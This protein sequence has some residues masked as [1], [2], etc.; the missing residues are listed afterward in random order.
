MSEKRRQDL[1]Y[2]PGPEAQH[3]QGRT[4][5][6]AEAEYLPITG[7][8]FSRLCLVRHDEEAILRVLRTV[9]YVDRLHARMALFQA[10]GGSYTNASPRA[11]ALCERVFGPGTMHFPIELSAADAPLQPTG[12]DPRAARPPAPRPGPG[13]APALDPEA[14]FDQGRIQIV[15]QILQR[16]VSQPP[17]PPAS[18][19]LTL[20]D[21]AEL[22]VVTAALRRLRSTP[23]PGERELGRT[24][25]QALQQ[26]A[27]ESAVAGHD[28]GRRETIERMIPVWPKAGRS[29]TPPP[30]PVETRRLHHGGRLGA[31]Q[32]LGSWDKSPT[33]A[34][35]AR[36]QTEAEERLA[37]DHPALAVLGQ[38]GGEPLPEA[39]LGRM[40]RIL[41][42]DFSHVRIHTDAAA[43]EAT[44]LLG[45]R[46]LA[47][48]AHVYFGAGQFAP[49]T[50]AGDRLL[51]HELVHVVQFDEGRLPPA[52]RAG[53][54]VSRPEDRAEQEAEARTQGLDPLDGA[55]PPRTATAAQ[56]IIPPR[57]AAPSSIPE[58]AAAVVHLQRDPGRTP[59]PT[60]GSTPGSTPAPAPTPTSAPASTTSPTPAPTPAGTTPAPQ[61]PSPS[62]APLRA[63]TPAAP[64]TP[65]RGPAATPGGPTPALSAPAPAPGPVGARGAG[66]PEPGGSGAAFADRLRAAADAQRQALTTKAN[67]VKASLGT[68]FDTE[69]QR[70]VTGFDQLL[71]R[72]ES[73]RDQALTALATRSE[74][75]KARVRQA[76][77]T[78]HTKLDA[79]LARQQSAARQSGETVAQDAITQAAAQ[80]DHATQGSATRAQRARDL[81]A[82][83]A[84]KFAGLDGGDSV[85]SD[86]RSKAGELA[87]TIESRASEARRMCADHGAK[88]AQDL[89][90]D[91]DDVARG[92][93]DKIKES[94]ERIDQ[95]RDDA[96]QAIDDGVQGAR[97]G[98]RQS[99]EQ[100]RQEIEQKKT[101]A[102]QGYDQLRDG[103]RAQVDAALA[104][105]T[106]KLEQLVQQMQRDVDDLVQAAAEIAIAPEVTAEAHAGIERTLAQHQAKLAEFGARGTASLGAVQTDAQAAATQQTSGIL[107]QTDGVANGLQSDLQNKADQCGAKVDES[108]R[109][110]IT[111]MQAVTPNVESEL[112]KGVT[113]GQAEWRKQLR[114]KIDTL[115]GRVDEALA[116]QDEQVDSLDRDLGRQYD[117]AKK[118]SDEAKKDKP[119]YEQAYD[120]VAGAIGAVFEFV[121]GI[122]VG[123]FEAAW[124]LLKGLWQL[125][126]TPLGWL[127]LAI[128][129]I[130][131]V[132]VVVL[133]GWEALIIA[134]IIIGICMAVYYVYLAVTTPGLSPYERGKLFGHALFEL[135]LGFIGVEWKG[136]SLLRFTKWGGLLP[137]AVRLVQE[138]GGIG[139]AI[140]LYRLIGSLDRA[141]QLIDKLG[142]V[143]RAIELVREVGGAE[144]LANLIEKCGS[145]EKLLQLLGNAKI[146]NAATLER[147]FANAKIG[148]VATLERLLG[149][150]KIADVATLERLLANAKIPNVATLERLL[151]N[152]KIADVAT[153]ERLL[154]NAKIGNVATLERLLGHAKIADVAT[155]ERL[156]ANAKIPDVAALERLLANA[157]ITDTATLE[158]L[159]ANTKITDVATLERLLS[160]AKVPNLAMLERLLANAKI[161]DASQLGR[162]LDSAI[163][164][165][166][167][168]LERILGHAKLADGAQL[169]ALLAKID[170]GARLERLLDA[171]DNGAQLLDFLTK[172]GGAGEAARLENLIRLAQG[173]QASRLQQ[174][175]DLAAGNSSKFEQLYRWTLTLS[176][177][178][179]KPPYAPPPQVATHG[180]AGANL[181][182]FLDHTFEY[183]DIA[184]RL[185]KP[186]TTFWPAHT[187]PNRIS[188]Y[189][190]EAL[191]LLNPA[192][193]PTRLPIPNTPSVIPTSGG[194][195]QVGSLPSN[196]VGM[197]FP[198]TGVKIVKQEMRA[199]AKILLP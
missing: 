32:L 186:G 116:K 85:A 109:A 167:A 19:I 196:I 141:V 171:T 37:G 179:P 135:V 111:D 80:G 161:A 29:P 127:L 147:L 159:L 12:E 9:P 45:A 68:A 22:H 47:F 1:G 193:S 17:F 43:A 129:V 35:K 155:L 144:K 26:A 64:T 133:F 79:A 66:A 56:A 106:A 65:G 124:E 145:V 77:T 62:P 6:H 114:D 91:A 99:F 44:Q 130:L 120:A 7:R 189:L 190:G 15:C 10:L 72:M 184:A 117:D 30:L 23:L 168:Q 139:K 115:R 24:Y 14:A 8:L 140:E 98:I 78:E 199:I 169:E 42:H 160:H 152:A 119:W 28:S 25:H 148:N 121:G 178:S 150:A 57:I 191:D 157:K 18:D 163:I 104:Q 73:A 165:H 59:T 154:A 46:A 94:R 52:R 118:K 158:R 76:A 51:A 151:G 100:T 3:E 92:M 61:A 95:D 39:V 86:V 11:V 181:P 194:P 54:E 16:L 134:G 188:Q 2:A 195:V 38:G 13:P 33:P 63:P 180:F 146:G 75:A 125:L 113:K 143:E 172:A 110:A 70:L 153:L 166:G 162:L 142:S 132:I 97:D 131:V 183:I 27:G 84:S 105:M 53:L 71:R 112:Q 164:G 174:L 108:A 69:R 34:A 48:G 128:A 67:E 82:R 149:N 31:G 89:R 156:L 123:F 101:Q 90:K 96:I 21:A 197:F 173:Q 4:H 103:A 20:L 49:G 88:I 126:S 177:R 107:S 192:G 93:A 187:P 138:A 102:T 137:R 185:N 136:G 182:H 198:T 122:I 170:S 81:G 36:R 87:R 58:R 5:P 60:P 83:W 176:Q 175:L 74:T 55:S 40:N 50:T 41:A